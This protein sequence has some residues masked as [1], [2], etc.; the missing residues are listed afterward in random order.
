MPEDEYKNWSEWSKKL[1]G[2][3][4][5]LEKKTD[6]LK[7]LIHKTD[8]EAAIGIAVLKAK[9]GIVG[10]ISGLVASAIVSII[11]GIIVYNLTK[12]M[13]LVPQ[14]DHKHPTSQQEDTLG[15]VLTPRENSRVFVD[16]NG[17]IIS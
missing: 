6:E 10:T 9:A 4:D 12:G 1:Q 16:V 11:V 8:R 3:V 17:E 2:S 14:R 13:E 7:D 5:K 15:K